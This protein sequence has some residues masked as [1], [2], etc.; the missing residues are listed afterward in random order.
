MVWVHTICSLLSYGA[1]LVACLTG[2]LFLIQERQ[3]KGKR[4]GLLFHRL[5]SLGRLGRLNFPA[6]S[7]GFLFLSIG[8]ACGFIGA[9]L[10]RGRW[11]SGDPKEVLTVAIWFSYFVL[12]LVRRR[13]T[14]RG[15]RVALLS[16]LGFTF[17]A[18][19]FIGTTWL[20]HSGHPF[21]AAG[22]RLRG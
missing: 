15:R 14:L 9:W 4:M 22:K 11:W 8:V 7:A 2:V 5:P 6:I 10:L 20:L 16:V 3:L 19:A 13:C 18:F 1:F 21:Y 17:L 12:W